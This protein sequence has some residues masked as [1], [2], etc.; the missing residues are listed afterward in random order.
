MS[1]NGFREG[2][3]PKS[4]LAVYWIRVICEQAHLCEVVA[5]MLG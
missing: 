2:T 5:K 4:L 1:F 3:L